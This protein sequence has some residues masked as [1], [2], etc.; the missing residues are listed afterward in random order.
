MKP[1]VASIEEQMIKIGP[2]E[3]SVFPH[4]GFWICKEDGEGMQVGEVKLI[5]LLERF[6]TE[7][8]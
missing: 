5:A 1:P 2:Y 4:G 8:F 7:E 3:I 6:W